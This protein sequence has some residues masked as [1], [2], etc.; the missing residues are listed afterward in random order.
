MSEMMN[1]AIQTEAVSNC[2][3]QQVVDMYEAEQ[4]TCAV[5]LKKV[6]NFCRKERLYSAGMIVSAAGAKIT[7]QLIME[8]ADK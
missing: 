7:A 4:E 5:E 2:I 6:H 8:E 1:Q 3:W